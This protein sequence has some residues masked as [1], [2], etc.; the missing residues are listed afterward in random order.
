[1]TKILSSKQTAVKHPLGVIM[2][3]SWSEKYILVSALFPTSYK[4]YTLSVK[5]SCDLMLGSTPPRTIIS[6]IEK[7]T[8]HEYCF[9]SGLM[10]ESFSTQFLDD[11][12]TFCVLTVFTSNS[13]IL[14]LFHLVSRILRF[15]TIFVSI[16]LSDVF[17]GL[18]VEG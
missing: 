13:M 15:S 4:E 6:S 14:L 2:L 10:L 9:T 11:S 8:V 5:V 7:N 16:S 12:V 17:R 3:I 18:L 1:M